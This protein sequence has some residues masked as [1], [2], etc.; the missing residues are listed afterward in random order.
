MRPWIAASRKKTESVLAKAVKTCPTNPE[1]RR[2]YADAL[3]QRGARPEAIAQLEE[4]C[5]LAPDIAAIRVRLAEMHLALGQTEPARDNAGNGHPLESQIGLC[6]GGQGRVMRAAGNLRQALADFHRA[7]GY[8][9]YDRQFL[10]EVAEL[11]GK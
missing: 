1:A 9:P 4:A 7:L 11:Y 5:H 2:D 10:L 8:A 6:L 3:W